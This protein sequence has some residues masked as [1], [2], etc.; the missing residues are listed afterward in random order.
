MSTGDALRI[1]IVDDHPMVVDGLRM[2]LELAGMHVVGTAGSVA[3]AVSAAT[4]HN[5][6]VIVMDIQLPDG[7]GVDATR[8]VLA[9][10]PGVAVLMLTMLD[11]PD[12]VMAAV[13]A[14]A[15]GY[16]VKGATRDE[17][18][19]A[20]TAVA[21]GEAIFGASVA[22]QVLAGAGAGPMPAHPSFD[23][24]FLTEREREIL[25]LVADG[26]GNVAIAD[27]LG[28][29]AKTVA[30]HVSML[31]TKLQVTDRTQAALL[32]RRGR[33]V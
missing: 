12:T 32:V 6:D 31:L 25:G 27:R 30:N 10:A 18:V 21:G 1:V 13:R 20:V 15:R 19:R 8:A 33:R 22:S 7:T 23:D 16:L 3:T 29:S 26:L 17:I 2:A 28:I 24:R 14:G 4:E 9:A 11:E 5:P